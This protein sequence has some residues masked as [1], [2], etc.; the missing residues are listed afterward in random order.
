MGT[1][2]SVEDIKIA[3]RGLLAPLQAEIDTPDAYLS[4]AAKQIIK[5]HGAYQQHD[6]EVRKHELKDEHYSFMLRVKIPGGQLSA[7]QYLTLDALAD[8]YANA[9][10]RLTTRQTVQFHGIIKHDLRGTI[11]GLNQVLLN[12]IGACGD[13]V[14]NVMAC[15]APTTDPQ[16]LAV[17]AFADKLSVAFMPQTRAYHQI[18]L[19]EDELI[20]EKLIEDPLYG[21]TYLPRK[22]KI[23]IAF[24]GDNCIDVFTQDVGL[25]A[26]FDDYQQLSGFNLL[27]GGGMGL[28]H[29]K[30]ETFARLADVIGFVTPE[31]VIEAVTAIVTIHRDY[32][33]RQ[34]RKHARL[35]YVLHDWGLER[36]RAVLQEHLNFNLQ[37]PRPMPAFQLEDHLGWHEQG[38][39]KWY[40]GLP[41]VSGRVADRGTNRLRSGLRTIIQGL[42]LPVRLTAQQNIL[43]VNID[44]KDRPT[45]ENLLIDY[46]ITA[47]QDLSG[48][49]RYGIACPALPTCGLAITEAERAFP[50]LLTEIEA[51]LEALDLWHNP[52]TIRMTGCPNGCARPYVAEIAFV[53]RSLDK[54]T[55]YL[56]GNAV[57]TRLAQPFRDLVAVEDLIPA[58]HP[59]LTY[60]RDYHAEDEAF[61]DFVQ[62]VG[63]E[64]LQNLVTETEA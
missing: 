13:I 1:K 58:L 14:R 31:Q 46:G 49:R 54:Y 29:N 63:F 35:K 55:L 16:R 32:G 21:T 57:G 23:G 24:P 38:D 28:T 50:G 42:N 62:R 34:N 3:S 36:F 4:E 25:V 20:D 17:Q 45:I 56:G 39:G 44:P 33:D 5:F 48:V 61:G 53:G 60:Y 8:T 7:A 18:W 30:A 9:T 37:D 12:S 64:T 47:A 2:P 43:L 27:V 51:V 11:Q 10:L 59:I 6:R 15:P 26:L 19:G 41:V 52:I 22:F 40:L